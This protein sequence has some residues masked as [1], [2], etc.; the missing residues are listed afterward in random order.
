VP[1]PTQTFA[2]LWDLTAPT[3]ATDNP[4][5]SSHI[6]I[7][8][9]RVQKNQFLKKKPNPLVLGFYWVLGFIVFFRFFI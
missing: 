5:F 3:A 6:D 2:D 7:Y 8:L 4:F 1:Q 9:N